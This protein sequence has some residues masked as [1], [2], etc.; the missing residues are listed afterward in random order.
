MLG[1]EYR[2]ARVTWT[3]FLVALAIAT[4]YAIRATLV[5]MAVSLFFAYMLMPLVGLVERFT[6]KRVSFTAALALVYLALIG[7]LVAFGITLGSRIADEASLLATRLPE[8][9]H[10]RQW[11]DSLPIPSWLNP[12]RDKVVEWIQSQ[13]ANGGKDLMPYVKNAAGQILS[14]AA[15]LLDIV[16][17]PIIAFFLLKDGASMRDSLVDSFV[18]PERRPVIEDMLADISRL[19]GQYIRALVLLSGASFVC[20]SLFLVFTGA[21]YAILLAGVAAAFDFIPVVGPLTAGVLVVTV[22]GLSGYD[23]VLWFVIFWV[24]FRL[25]QDYVL[26]PHLMSAGVELHPMLVLAGV[27]AGERVAGVAGMFFSVPVI[28]T[29][30]V[31]FVRL[32]RNRRRMLETTSLKI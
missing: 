2:A 20:Y 17:V 12:L 6:P 4:A 27:L 7:A 8:L 32:Q 1:I 18:S 19:L 28:A 3:V 30:R 22:T 10:N 25:F 9:A 15:Y 31:I 11:I 29:L 5:V 13:F 23:H 21:P 14:G 16:L 24:V 26:S